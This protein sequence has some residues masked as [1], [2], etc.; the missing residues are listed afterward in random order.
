MGIIPKNVF[1]G[2][3]RCWILVNPKHP[4]KMHHNKG[5]MISSAL[6]KVGYIG[7]KTATSYTSVGILF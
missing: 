2:D 1:N 5:R 6:I 7:G 3:A 4:H